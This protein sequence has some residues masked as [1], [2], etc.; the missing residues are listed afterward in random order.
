MS[1][2]QA[3]VGYLTLVAL[4]CVLALASIGYDSERSYEDG[5]R[6][7]QI[8]ALSGNVKYQLVTRIDSSR[9]W[10]EVKEDLK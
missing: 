3:I 8:D 4:L 10:V 5:Y 2:S 1:I 6:Q 9:V 7:G